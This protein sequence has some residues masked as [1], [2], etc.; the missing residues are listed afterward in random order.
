M[1]RNAPL[2]ALVS[3]VTQAGGHFFG[4]VLDQRAIWS[5][6]PSRTIAAAGAHARAVAQTAIEMQVRPLARLSLPQRS[7]AAHQSSGAAFVDPFL[8]LPRSRPTDTLDPLALS[9]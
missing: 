8:I 4:T 5:L 2:L 9:R 3:S 7:V 6:D 1:R